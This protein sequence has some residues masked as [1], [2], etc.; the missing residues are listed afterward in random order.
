M[1][2]QKS[3][4]LSAP[5]HLFGINQTSII[6]IMRCGIE[7]RRTKSLML[8]RS[9]YFLHVPFRT[10]YSQKLILSFHHTADV[11]RKRLNAVNGRAFTCKIANTFFLLF[12]C[13]G[14]ASNNGPSV[15]STFRVKK[16]RVCRC[17]TKVPP[18]W[19]ESR[20]AGNEGHSDCI[21]NLWDDWK[22]RVEDCQSSQDGCK[23]AGMEESF[24]GSGSFSL[25]GFSNLN[26]RVVHCHP[27]LLP[28][29]SRIWFL[30]IAS[31][32]SLLCNV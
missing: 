4:S 29:R 12:F 13:A 20:R 3:P 27:L 10:H 26:L 15:G 19:P 32:S 9:K 31:S 11:G 25:L 8:T 21:E 2:G 5:I 22:V 16:V 6:I 18:V 23:S 14:L 1:K 7:R 30:I 24:L 28:L 17:D